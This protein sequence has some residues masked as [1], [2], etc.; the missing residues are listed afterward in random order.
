[1]MNISIRNGKFTRGMKIALVSFIWFAEVSFV[2]IFVKIRSKEINM[3]DRS[4]KKE[5]T[6]PPLLLCPPSG[7]LTL[8]P[9]QG[10]SLLM[11]V[12][13][14]EASLI[15]SGKYLMGYIKLTA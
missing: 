4:S 9:A 10:S 13:Q 8:T 7:G 1:M 6:P 15:P 3:A 5:S 2:Y 12:P 14:T 11:P